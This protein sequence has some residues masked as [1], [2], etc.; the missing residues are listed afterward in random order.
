M[1]AVTEHHASETRASIETRAGIET[2]A[3]RFCILG[4]LSMTVHGREAAPTAAKQRQVLCLLLMNVGRRV[5]TTALTSELWPNEVP[6][7]AKTALQTYISA[8]RRLFAKELGL[9][10]E[11][12]AAS[13]LTTD[14]GSYTLHLPASCWDGAEFQALLEQGEGAAARGDYEEA[15]TTLARA[16]SMCQGDI[17]EDVVKGPQLRPLARFLDEARLHGEEILVDTFLRTGKKNQ[18]VCRA[19]TLADRNPYHEGLHA[20]LMRSLYAAGRR[21]DALKAYRELDA[22][23]ADELGTVPSPETRTLHHVLLQDAPDAA[24]LRLAPVSVG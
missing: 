7:T 23:L 8:L 3:L 1:T 24:F 19:T 17:L 16:L 6:R 20:Q 11:T 18:A 12:V 9:P 21:N 13:L 2:E 15:E 10:A 22:R 14:A 5:T 4:P